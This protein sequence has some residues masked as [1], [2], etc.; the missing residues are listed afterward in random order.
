MAQEKIIVKKSFYHDFTATTESNY[1]ARI[2]DARKI[3]NFDKKDG[4][5]E[6]TDV[7]DY[8]ENQFHV[9]RENIVVID[10]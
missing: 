1:N 10:G 2:Q 7:V 5:N 3:W 8:I 4:F 6:I 9:K